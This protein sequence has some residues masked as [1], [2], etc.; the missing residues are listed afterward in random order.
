ML[1]I[2]YDSKFDILYISI[3]NPVPSYGE[4]KT[5]GL[6]VL[7]NIETDE[8]TGIT[9]FD[10]MRRVKDNTMKDLEIPIEIDINKISQNINTLSQ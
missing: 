5:P 10:F 8:I 4:E 9:I 6:V 7:K 2:D 3:G 1:K